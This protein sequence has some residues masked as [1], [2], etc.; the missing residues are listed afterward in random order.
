MVYETQNLLTSQYTVYSEIPFNRN[1]YHIETSQLVKAN[2]K[3]WFD[4]EIV[5]AIQR[6]DKVFKKFKHSG[7]E[8]GKNNFKVAKIHLQKMIL[9]KM[10]SYFEEELGKN[11]NK[12]KEL[13]KTLKSL[14][15]NSDKARQSKIY[16]NKDGAI[17]F[18]ALENRNTFKSFYS[19]LAG[20]LQG[21]LP[22]APNKLTGQTTKNYYAKTSCNVSDEFEFSN[23]SE[24][25]VKKILLSLD[26]SK[27]TGMDQIPAKF[28]RDSAEV[29]ALPFRN[30]II[31]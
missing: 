29:L 6:Q 15:L 13:W 4:N 21:K 9:K 25:D 22:R 3:P 20:G 24:E 17:Q 30:I 31:L 23:V 12:P 7:L 14:G 2:S 10:K 16:L 8:T 1:L 18:E 26:T 28:L 19:E 5:S 11:R 27:A